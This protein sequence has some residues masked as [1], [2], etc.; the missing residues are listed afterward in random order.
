MLA[1]VTR[2]RF[3]VSM[4]A[5]YTRVAADSNDNF[6]ALGT[7]GAIATTG[8]R[9]C[10]TYHDRIGNALWQKVIAS[11][12]E[13]IFAADAKF[14]KFGNPHVLL[15]GSEGDQRFALVIKFDPDGK[16][17]FRHVHP[18]D[19]GVANRMAIDAEGGVIVAGKANA[20]RLMAYKVDSN[21][22]LVWAFARDPASPQSEGFDLT[23]DP[24]GD[25]YIAGQ[26][27]DSGLR[28]EITKLSGRSGAE[29]FSL[30][31]GEETGLSS[32]ARRI[33][34][35]SN[36]FVY[37]AGEIARETGTFATDL[38]LFG[39]LST[40][41]TSLSTQTLDLGVGTRAEVKDL[42][43]DGISLFVAGNATGTEDR[44][45]I[46]K[47][48]LNLVSSFTARNDRGRYAGAGFSV[49]RSALFLVTSTV[50]SVS[51]VRTRSYRSTDG[52]VGAERIVGLGT[53]VSSVGQAVTQDQQG[54]LIVVGSGGPSPRFILG[55]FDQ[56]GGE[57]R[58]FRFKLT[59]TLSVFWALEQ[60]V[61]GL[62][63]GDVSGMVT[64]AEGNA[65]VAGTLAA[66][67]ST[68]FVFKVSRAGQVLWKATYNQTANSR[69][70]VND[71]G[72][73]PDGNLVIVGNT[74]NLAGTTLVDVAVIKIDSQTGARI[75]THVFDGDLSSFD[76]GNSLALARSG[77][78]L[79][80]GTSRFNLFTPDILTFRL[81]G[82]TGALE[83]V[84]YFD[85][86]SNGTD[87]GQDVQVAPNGNVVVVG[88]SDRDAITL[89]YSSAGK[90]LWAGIAAGDASDRD[91]ALKSVIGADNSVF[92]L[93]HL[94]NTSATGRELKGFVRY[95]GTTGFE[96]SRGFLPSLSSSFLD[97][98]DVALDRDGNPLILAGGNDIVVGKIE[99]TT[100]TRIFDQRFDIA[101]SSGERASEI[102]VDSEGRI[103]VLTSPARGFG[104]S[105][106]NDISLMRLRPTGDVAKQI[107]FQ[108]VPGTDHPD[109]AKKLALGLAGDV[110]VAGTA[111]ASDGG[112]DI[113]LLRFRQ[114]VSPVAASDAY[115]TD[116][117]QTLTVQASAGVL[118]NDRDPNGDALTALLV[119]APPAGAGI[120][121]LDADGSFVFTPKLNFHGTTSFRYR[122]VDPGGLRSAITTASIVVTAIN[123]APRAAG[124]SFSV[125]RG[126]TLDIAA[127][128]VLANDR[129]ADGDA[130]TAQL[131]AGSLVGG[132]QLVFR[133]DG[134]LT[135]AA[136]AQ[137]GTFTF[138]YQAQDPS[139]LKSAKVRVTITITE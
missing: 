7:T 58:P 129:D 3:N 113:V 92:S 66:R 116:E 52:L 36:G 39:R 96:M 86:F 131:V 94:V 104:G 126:Q 79:V 115:A 84:R 13:L 5:T 114:N 71:I 118:A 83:W 60:K 74:Q 32:R 88:G 85:S 70:T 19:N 75:W 46:H 47:A 22:G 56:T 6:V 110:W 25:V 38:V 27:A 122:A 101:G 41:G 11:N 134:S 4:A 108:N 99:A 67:L 8:G 97:V 21:G 2:Q 120:L 55:S 136:P 139:G 125:A 18:L 28:A 49:A 109:R 50:D 34:L 23:T 76:E 121:A 78:V 57:T 90:P 102:A 133:T 53:N 132:G 77:D 17:L 137:T 61:P 33:F 15:N 59:P 69:D 68:G 98:E 73:G 62:I 123:D 117:D 31:I 138:N 30:Q 95:D 29:L 107:F 105:G 20:S 12:L 64:D 24:S 44:P 100:G 112:D 45:F 10:L 35:A 54:N 43:S 93:V 63:G 130:L 14:D 48:S 1:K 65:Y 51:Q 127:P 42:F 80:A 89:A 135:Y 37:F 16:E 106:G 128:G 40:I 87:E 72:I 26:E 81:D 91:F 119:T 124:D 111:I 103:L 9:A 82:A